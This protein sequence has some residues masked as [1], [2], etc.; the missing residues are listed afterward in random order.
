M[1]GKKKMEKIDMDNTFK[2]C[3]CEAKTEKYGIGH[4]FWNVSVD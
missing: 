1:V 3:G 2:K 4:R